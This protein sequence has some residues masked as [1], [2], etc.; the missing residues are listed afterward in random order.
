VSA[1]ATLKLEHPSV[2]EVLW[3]L[4]ALEQSPSVR[5]ALIISLATLA[6]DE[7]RTRN[8]VVRSSADDDAQVRFAARSMLGNRD[9]T[10]A[11]TAPG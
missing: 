7:S 9:A 1:A 11:G 5:S 3:R 8:F 10:N 2:R 4:A 6:P